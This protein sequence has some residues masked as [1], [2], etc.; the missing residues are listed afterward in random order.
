M[1]NYL[2]FDY[3]KICHI[4]EFAPPFVKLTISLPDDEPPSN[5]KLDKIGKIQ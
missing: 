4:I 1:G 5:L 3:S 2:P